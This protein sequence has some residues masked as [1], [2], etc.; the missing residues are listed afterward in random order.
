MPFF[1]STVAAFLDGREVRRA[2]LVL[3]DLASGPYRLW[4]NGSGMLRT[5]DGNMWAG[6]GKIGQIGDIENGRGGQATSTTF[7]L[8][9]VDPQN[10]A[11]ALDASAQAKG[12][13]VRVYCQH[14]DDQWVPLDNPYMTFGG[15]MDTLSIK[16]PDMSKRTVSLSA[17][18]MFTAR[19]FAPFAYASDLDQKRLHPGDRLLERMA[20]M[21]DKTILWPVY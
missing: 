12:R 3:F 17:E 18:G 8:S 20:Q 6:A 14:Y 2:R 1:S 11:A 15:V 4:E 10:L 9:G 21:A 19:G 7:S 5:P 16:A 13:E